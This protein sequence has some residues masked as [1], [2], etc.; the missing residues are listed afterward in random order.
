MFAVGCPSMRD[1]LTANPR[2]RSASA[3]CICPAAWNAL[4]LV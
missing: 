1:R 2:R 4:D 3:A